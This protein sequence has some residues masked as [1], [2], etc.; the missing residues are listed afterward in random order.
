MSEQS[1]IAIPS[2]EAT[3]SAPV[4]SPPSVDAQTEP[5]RVV[6]GEIVAVTDN[7]QPRP[8]P[9]RRWRVPVLFAVL[10]VVSLVAG[11]S[12]GLVLSPLLFATATIT[13]TPESH[14]LATAAS[15]PLTVRLFPDD[16]ES[17]SRTIAATG[18]AVHPATEAHGSIKFYNG[19]PAPQTVPA[20]TLLMSTSGIPVLTEDD[21]YI[22]AASPPTEGSTTVS[23]RAEN[24]GLAGNIAAGTIGGPCCRAYV[25]AYNGPF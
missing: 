8:G 9:P 14:S 6:V 11:A 17:L 13:L 16:Q 19:L 7:Y 23:A 20:G 12:A 1:T 22:P 24:T 25:L 18:T 10:A 4:L 2:I 21:A 15:I 5:P 3:P